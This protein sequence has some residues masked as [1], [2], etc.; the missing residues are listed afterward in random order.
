MTDIDNNKLMGLLRIAGR[1]LLLSQEH[2]KVSR[3][4]RQRTRPWI[5]NIFK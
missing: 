4:R 3:K 1:G 5:I 2:I